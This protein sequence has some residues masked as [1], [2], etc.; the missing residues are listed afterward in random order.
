[1]RWFL[2]RAWRG[3]L[4]FIQFVNK[5]IVYILLGVVFFLLVTPQA[6]FRRVVHR[7]KKEGGLLRVEHMYSIEDL[8]KLW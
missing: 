1:M 7:G 4:Y 5:G 2:K 6:V 3:W 8:K